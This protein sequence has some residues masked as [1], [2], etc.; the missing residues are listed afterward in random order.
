MAKKKVRK[1]EVVPIPLRSYKKLKC[2]DCGTEYEVVLG[3]NITSC[4]SCGSTN[5]NRIG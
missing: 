5:S 4:P 3:N 2:L 1:K